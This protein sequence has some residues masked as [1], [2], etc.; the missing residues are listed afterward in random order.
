VQELRLLPGPRTGSVE[1]AEAGDTLPGWAQWTPSPAYAL[2]IEE[3]VMILDPSD[4]SLARGTDGLLASLSSEFAPHVRGETH[5]AALELATAPHANAEEAAREVAALRAALADHT[6][7]AGLQAAGAGTHPFA[8]WTET[9]V[10]SGARYQLIHESMRELARREPTFAL[11]VHIGVGDPSSGIALL[12]RLRAHVP[13]LLALSA[14]SPF[15]Q[16]RDTGLASARTPIFQ[17]FPRVGIPRPFSSYLEYVDAVDQM[18]R[19]DAFPEPS[20]LWW[21]VRPRP[22]FG[23]IEVR[24]MDAQSTAE[25][26]AALAA[27]VQ[28]IAHLELEEGYHSDLLLF[29]PEILDENRFLASRD[30]MDARLLDP[31]L[32]TRVPATDQLAH[33]LSAVRPHA[34]ELGCEN[35]LEVVE[36]IGRDNGAA[37][38]RRMARGSSLGGMVQTLAEDFTRR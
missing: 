1:M 34:E 21:D 26:S 8:M 11:H 36:A 7:R 12:N 35:A 15:W 6:E 38:Q 17:S 37:R 14:N 19:C 3:E 25:R 10:S 13:L 31:V 20:F 30:G 18:L 16:G 22:H 24:V 5:E 4:W 2:G 28:S 27:L 9:R 33:L 29:A 32:E 23:T